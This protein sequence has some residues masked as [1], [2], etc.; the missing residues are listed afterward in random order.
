MKKFCDLGKNELDKEYNDTKEERSDYVCDINGSKINIEVNNNDSVETMYRNM[1]Y[2]FRLYNEKVKIGKKYKS[3]YNQVIQINL[4]NYSFIGNDKI[5]DTYSFQ[6]DKGIVL[7]D[8]IIILEIY[9][10]T[11]RKKCYTLGKENLCEVEKYLLGLIEE[12][13][14][15]LWRWGRR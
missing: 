11:L 15:Y 7:N 9:V 1:E 5:I 14:K 3:L 13:M 8:K 10:P 2:A 4:N 12:N 6:N